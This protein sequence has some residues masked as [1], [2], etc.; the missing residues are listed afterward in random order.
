MTY[1]PIFSTLVTFA[2]T[3]AVFRRYQLKG[4]AHLLHWAFGLLLYGFGTLSEVVLSYTFNGFLLRLWY[5]CGAMLTAA[6]LGQGSIHLLIRKGDWAKYLT[7]ALGA[8]SLVAVGL[9][10]MAPFN[11]AAAQAYQIARPASEQYKEIMTRSGLMVFF[12][13]FLNIYG[14]LGLVGGA[15]YSAFLFWRK[16]VLVNRML[17]NVLIA[18]GG[19]SPAIGGTFVQN[20]MV[21]LL[22][23]SEL[24][25]AILMFIGFVMATS[26][27]D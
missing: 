13:V 19:L 14:T 1:L 9:V 15:L 4:G 21:D 16:K 27:K 10:F 2:F 22:Y 3:V 6:W 8:V 24:L 20:G 7:Y 11:D 12:T 18:A 5:L 17:G 25:G 23:L 26:G